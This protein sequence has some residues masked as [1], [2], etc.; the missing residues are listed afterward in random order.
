V[1]ELQGEKQ[2][3]FTYQLEVV[4]KNVKQSFKVL[5]NKIVIVQNLCKQCDQNHV[6]FD[7]LYAYVFMHNMIIKNK[8]NTDWN[9]GLM[10]IIS[11][12]SVGS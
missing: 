4:W 2:K 6:V 9:I 5:Q 7:I 12:S 8:E 3:H 1:N 10:L 11:P